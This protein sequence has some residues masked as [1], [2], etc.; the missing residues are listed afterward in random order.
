M[1]FPKRQI[2]A[3]SGVANA[4][5]G[6]GKRLII[7][8]ACVVPKQT[9][10]SNISWASVSGGNSGCGYDSTITVHPLNQNEVYIWNKGG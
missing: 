2:L 6:N 1:H 9:T 4:S 3:T 7:S 10:I 8:G 5:D